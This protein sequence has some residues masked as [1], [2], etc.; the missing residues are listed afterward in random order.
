MKLKAVRVSK[1]VETNDILPDGKY[2]GIIGGSFVS[3]HIGRGMYRIETDQAVRGLNIPCVIS[4][5]KGKVI[6]EL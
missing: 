3:F 4:V 1:L 2:C 6:V 5:E